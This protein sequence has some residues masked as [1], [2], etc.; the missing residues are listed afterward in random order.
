M[1]E[2]ENTSDSAVEI[3]PF[4]FT[5]QDASGF[6]FSTAFAQGEEG[7]EMPPLSEATEVEGGESLE[8]LIVFNVFEEQ[9]LAHLFWQPDSDRLVTLAQL[10]GE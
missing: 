9:P 1:L 3:D 2:F 4:R 7:A 6:I 8:A 10:E 5:L